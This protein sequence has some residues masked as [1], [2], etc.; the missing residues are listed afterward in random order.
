MVMYPRFRLPLLRQLLQ[1][2]PAVAI[3]G[4]RQV[5]KTTLAM[6]L[7]AM[8]GATQ[9][10]DLESPADAA[11]LADPLSYFESR[12]DRLVVIDEVQRAPDLFPVLRGVIDQ[13]RRQGQRA[14]QFLL[15]GSATGAL[16]AQSAE[17][18]AGRI[19]YMELQSLTINEV[20][21]DDAQR[22][23]LRGGFPES[24]LARSDSASLRWRQQFISTYL[25]RDIPQLGPRIP[26]ETLR[27]LWTML[28]HEQGQL[29]NASKLATSL[30]VSGQTV[31][32]YIDLLCDLMLVRRLLPWADNGGKRL[33]RAPKVYVR[34]SGLVHALLGLGQ[35]DEV[36]SHPV[37][38]GSWEGWVIENL[39]AVLPEGAQ[40]FF[41]RSS[42]GAELDLVLDLPRKQ[43]WAIEVKRST[44]PTVGRGFHQAAGDIDATARFVVHSGTDAYPL[45]ADIEAIPVAEL[46]QRLIDLGEA[47]ASAARKTPR[48]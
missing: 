17:S 22:L 30:A 25:E 10:L 29:L 40:S 46:Q 13:R 33:V 39:L 9:Y 15:L 27:R 32:R 37:V 42:A 21:S 8:D 16:L 5:G 11:K 26:A 31:T 2:F 35:L 3:L 28:A 12:R 45:S 7:L 23:W 20:P 34:D 47:P 44:A 48:R 19:A 43:R 24:L 6:E 14:G 36:L 4:P 18:L 41:Y 1:E 38:G